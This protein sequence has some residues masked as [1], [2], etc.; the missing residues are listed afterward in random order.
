MRHGC[1]IERNAL[2]FAEGTKLFSREVCAVISYDAAWDAE[3]VDGGL[4]EVNCRSSSR[5]CDGD[6]F[7]PLCE[8]VDCH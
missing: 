3:A 5:I 8:L 4:Y 2:L 7:D 6:C 1:I